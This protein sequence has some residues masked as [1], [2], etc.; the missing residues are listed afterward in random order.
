MG[1]SKFLISILAVLALVAMLVSCHCRTTTSPWPTQKPLETIATTSITVTGDLNKGEILTIEFD[2]KGNCKQTYVLEV[3]EK[4]QVSKEKV[5][6][7]CQG[8]T[9]NETFYCIVPDPEDTVHVPNTVIYGKQGGRT[10]AY[11]GNVLELTDGADI[12]F[13]SK[14]T[15]ENKKCKN[16]GGE[17]ICYPKKK[18]RNN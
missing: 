18:K 13:E 4:G 7:N 14:S 5:P 9:L 15:D 3:D 16:I 8:F 17:V 1:K 6:T 11:C 2:K 10:E 12:R